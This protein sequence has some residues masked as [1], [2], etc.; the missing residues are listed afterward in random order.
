[1]IYE[2]DTSPASRMQGGTLDIH[3][4]IDIVALKEAGLY[5]QFLMYSQS[6]GEDFVIADKTEVNTL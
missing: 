2:G 1:M 6:E 4:N 5:D 3:D